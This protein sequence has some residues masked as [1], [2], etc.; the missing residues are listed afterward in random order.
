MW[1]LTGVPVQT[2]FIPKERFDGISA[3]QSHIRLRR[4]VESFVH[5][6]SI[7]R[8]D[9]SERRCKHC[10]L[11]QW[12]HGSSGGLCSNDVLVDAL[13]TSCREF[14]NAA[15]YAVEMAEAGQ[16]LVAR[17]MV[18]DEGSF[19]AASERHQSGLAQLHLSCETV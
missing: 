16:Q 10:Y 3:I 8:P 19:R 15:R 18:R 9:F 17:A 5:G 6:E 12:L 13:H 7:I 11:R 4:L 1:A 14:Q 2:N